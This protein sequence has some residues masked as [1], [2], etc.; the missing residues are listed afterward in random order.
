MEIIEPAFGFLL[1]LATISGR[2]HSLETLRTY[3]EHLYDCFD[4]LEQSDLDWQA[5]DEAMVAAYRN[6]APT[7]VDPMR[8]PRSMIVSAPSVA[9]MIGH[10]GVVV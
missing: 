3:A 4:S 6:T 8:A 7:P 5:A 2:S 10:I 1:E 9:S